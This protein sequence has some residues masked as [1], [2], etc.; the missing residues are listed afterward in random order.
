MTTRCLSMGQTTMEDF[1]DA[2][3]AWMDHHILPSVLP[4]AG[5]IPPPVFGEPCPTRRGPPDF[6]N[7]PVFSPPARKNIMTRLGKQ[8]KRET[9]PTKDRIATTPALALGYKIPLT[10]EALLRQ[11]RTRRQAMG[12]ELKD[13]MARIREKLSQESTETADEEYELHAELEL[14]RQAVIRLCRE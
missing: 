6:H 2:S 3:T 11:T 1:P 8:H 7:K 13:Q 5:R 4:W 10:T 14:I 12:A 9:T